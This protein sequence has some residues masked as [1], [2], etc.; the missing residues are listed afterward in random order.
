MCDLTDGIRSVTMC[1]AA[2]QSAYDRQFVSIVP[3]GV[4]AQSLPQPVL[5]SEVPV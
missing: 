2:R 4:D 3:P 5:A 1:L